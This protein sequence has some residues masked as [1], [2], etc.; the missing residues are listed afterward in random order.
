MA[1]QVIRAFWASGVSDHVTILHDTMWNN[2]SGG[3]AATTQQPSTVLTVAHLGLAVEN[4]S[5][6]HDHS[7]FLAAIA[8]ADPWLGVVQKPTTLVVLVVRHG[9]QKEAREEGRDQSRRGR[10]PALV[11][12]GVRKSQHRSRVVHDF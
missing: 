5:F 12:Q 10:L 7:A 6:G 3:G 8:I 9:S 4:A 2:E 1:G 11:H